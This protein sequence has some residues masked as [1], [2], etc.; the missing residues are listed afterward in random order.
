M[1]SIC[2]DC[3]WAQNGGCYE[4]EMIGE[5]KNV[6]TI[7]KS[8]NFYSTRSRARIVLKN[9]RNKHERIRRNEQEI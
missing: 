8:N 5:K 3:I 2:N 4:P 7:S 6:T 1:N 9:R